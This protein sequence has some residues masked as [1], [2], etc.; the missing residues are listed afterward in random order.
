MLYPTQNGHTPLHCAIDYG[1]SE[2]VH[3]FVIECKQNIDGKWFD[4]VNLVMHM[5]ICICIKQHLYVYTYH[6]TPLTVD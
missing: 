2:V 5:Y 4:E 6:C 3:Y 1:Y